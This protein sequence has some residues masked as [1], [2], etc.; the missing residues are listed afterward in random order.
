MPLT[1]KEISGKQ[2][3]TG[4]VGLNNLINMTIVK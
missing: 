1:L 2:F 3:T 4:I